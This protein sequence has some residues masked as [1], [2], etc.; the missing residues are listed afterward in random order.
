[1]DE[2]VTY[3]VRCNDNTLYCG[4]TNDISKRLVTHNEGKGSKYTMYRLPVVLVMVSKFLS[5]C[6]ALRLER[7]VKKQ[8]ANEKVDYLRKF[9]GVEDG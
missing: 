2:W 7:A 1:M 6:D 4:A 3:L 9:S 8:K 5:K